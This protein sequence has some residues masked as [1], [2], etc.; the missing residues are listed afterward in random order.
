MISV[1]PL[2]ESVSRPRILNMIR[3]GLDGYPNL[4]VPSGILDLVRYRLI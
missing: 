1:A 3:N 2:V 4:T